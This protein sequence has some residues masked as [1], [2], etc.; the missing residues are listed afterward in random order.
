[1]GSAMRKAFAASFTRAGDLFRSGKVELVDVPVPK[2]V[3]NKQDP[4]NEHK[5]ENPGAPTW[6]LTAEQQQVVRQAKVIVMDQHSGEHRVGTRHVCGCGTI[7]GLITTRRERADDGSPTYIHVDSS[8]RVPAPH[9]GSACGVGKMLKGAGYNVLGF[10]RRASSRLD[11]GL[12][13]CADHVTSDLETVLSQS[14]IIENVLP[15]T[16]ATRYLLNKNNLKCCSEPTSLYQHRTWRR[17][18]CREDDYR[19]F[20]QWHVV[21]CCI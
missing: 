6:D 13:A 21:T 16:S 17:R 3:G 18:R 20:G 12:S 4:L 8:W 9:H 15:S 7:F 10:K 11:T 14:D 1:M 2:L 19:R 5:M